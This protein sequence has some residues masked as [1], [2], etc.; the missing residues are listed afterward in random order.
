MAKFTVEQMKVKIQGLLAKAE[1]TDSVEEQ[2]SLTEA[3]ERLML[4]L[5]IEAA[6][7]E[8]SGTVGPQQA[9]KAHRDFKNIYAKPMMQFIHT[10]SLGYGN[11]EC[12]QSSMGGDLWRIYV[13]G[14]ESDVEQ[15]L[16]LVDSLALQV[17]S[18]LKRWIRESREARRYETANDKWLG[19]RSFVLGYGAEVGKRLRKMRTEE[20]ATASAGAALVLVDKT[21]RIEVFKEQQ[22]PDLRSS[23]GNR[24]GN[25]DG[26]L[27]GR[28]A[29]REAR[30][31]QDT[32]LPGARQAL[33]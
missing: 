30:L 22:F 14:I 31:G 8:A 10:V 28:M 33:R 13:L 5:G 4:K 7:L 12:I 32:P 11:I 3:A 25:M 27:S 16:E 20:E 2:Q 21:A 18:A 1:S 23:R 6:E 19:N 17:Q 29:G 24:R 15:F 9:V 26:Y